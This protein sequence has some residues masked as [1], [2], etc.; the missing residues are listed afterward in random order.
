MLL[1]LGHNWRWTIMI[2][3]THTHSTSHKMNNNE[4]KWLKST[5]FFI[6]LRHYYCYLLCNYNLWAFLLKFYDNRAN[7]RTHKQTKRIV[8]I[9]FFHCLIIMSMCT[10]V[11]GLFFLSKLKQMRHFSVFQCLFRRFISYATHCS[12]SVDVFLR[13][14]FEMLSASKSNANHQ[15]H[16]E[17]F[18]CTKNEKRC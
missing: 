10:N 16:P 13:N 1:T 9:A 3:I 18:R 7:A 14:W 11:F 17:P 5:I 4:T 6:V 12:L 8:M 2:F 15:E